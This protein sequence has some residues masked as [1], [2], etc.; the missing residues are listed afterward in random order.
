MA[1]TNQ[2]SIKPREA[3]T[4][5]SVSFSPAIWYAVR[6]CVFC[7]CT[8]A[9][10]NATNEMGISFRRR[11]IEYDTACH[12]LS[13]Y[14]A[15][16]KQIKCR[17]TICDTY[18]NRLRPLARILL[19][20]QHFAPLPCGHSLVGWLVWMD[21]F[22]FTVSPAYMIRNISHSYYHIMPIHCEFLYICVC[23]CVWKRA[24]AR[25]CVCVCMAPNDMIMV[26][27]AR[28]IAT[29][30]TTNQPTSFRPFV[31]AK[32]RILE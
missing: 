6:M 17:R 13:T 30:S 23:V 7:V 1:T 10:A 21:L 29:N 22:A 3:S 16:L 8:C 19:V 28:P 5:N 31:S 15:P 4:R 18:R 27:G 11:R 24:G 9:C 14:I 32:F 25:E 12:S 26:C 2:K 20:Q